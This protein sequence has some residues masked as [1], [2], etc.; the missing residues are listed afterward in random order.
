MTKKKQKNQQDIDMASVD[1]KWK[2]KKRK[3]NL[4]SLNPMAGCLCVW[5]IVG[6]IRFL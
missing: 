6:D 5:S 1:A 2:E 3:E 4:L